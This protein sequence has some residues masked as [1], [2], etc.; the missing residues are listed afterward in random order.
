MCRGFCLESRTCVEII[1]LFLPKSNSQE[2]A[3]SELHESHLAKTLRYKFMI[4]FKCLDY[5]EDGEEV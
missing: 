3:S 2:V 4:I 5:R 1:L